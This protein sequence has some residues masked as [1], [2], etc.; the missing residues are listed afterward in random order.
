MARAAGVETGRRTALLLIAE[1]AP[2]AVLTTSHLQL[3]LPGEDGDPA[4]EPR[5]VPRELARRV[6]PG[7][8][9]DH[10]YG[11]DAYLDFHGVVEREHRLKVGT[12]RRL[13]ERAGSVLLGDMSQHALGVSVLELAGGGSH[14]RLELAHHF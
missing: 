11:V 5:E 4:V 14:L 1:E 8:I 7:V 6:D 12:Q 9:A 2:D 10:P 3:A 13:R